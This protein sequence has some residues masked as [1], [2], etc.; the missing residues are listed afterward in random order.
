VRATQNTEYW[1]KKNAITEPTTE[2]WPIWLEHDE[3]YWVWILQLQ[4]LLMHCPLTEMMTFG[5]ES[6]RQQAYLC[7]S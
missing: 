6:K 3:S 2:P 1:K 5:P 4:I 7:L